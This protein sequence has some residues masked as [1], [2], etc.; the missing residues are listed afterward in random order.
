MPKPLLVCKNPSTALESIAPIL[1]CAP[2]EL[3]S[4]LRQLDIAAHDCNHDIELIIANRF[5][6]TGNFEDFEALGFHGT[7][8]SPSHSILVDGLLPTS[9]VKLKLLEYLRQLGT[10][11]SKVGVSPV[12]GSYAMKN[13]GSH[14]D[15]GPF[16]MLFYEVVAHP[17]GANGS[18][19][20]CPELI[21]DL[22]GEMLGE[23][24][25]HLI[26]RFKEDSHPH[27]VHFRFSPP[28]KTRTLSRALLYTYLTHLDEQD[29]CDVA[30]STPH[31]FDGNGVAIP[32]EN[33]I[34]IEKIA[35]N[36]AT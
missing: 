16:G 28:D 2:Q 8:L 1:R 18:Y 6:S 25:I 22:A 32:P 34:E 11:L 33:I 30:N 23:N 9:Q 4:S 20:D 31:C 3:L 7:R 15:E 12:G 10:G 13:S 17:S 36:H 19:I 26:N 24:S 14:I 29:S 21:A 27:I 35:S 5:L